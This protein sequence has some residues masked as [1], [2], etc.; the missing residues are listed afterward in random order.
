MSQLTHLHLIGEGSNDKPASI[1]TFR[2][3]RRRN[4]RDGPRFF[5]L[6]FRLASF[7]V[8]YVCPVLENWDLYVVK[9]S[10]QTPSF[11]EIVDLIIQL[12]CL[13]FYLS[14]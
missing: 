4:S 9:R 3:S 6:F 13:F 12:G 1:G 8:G 10:L 2:M 5:R 11:D 7:V 14:I